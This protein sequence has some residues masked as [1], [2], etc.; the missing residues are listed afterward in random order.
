ME[1]LRRELRWLGFSGIKT[2]YICPVFVDTGFAKN[3]KSSSN[4]FCPILKP[5]D[6]VN[7][8]MHAFLT[9]QPSLDVPDLG[10]SGRF[11]E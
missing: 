2:T 4:F 8:A 9:D 7:K 10:F 5:E 1:G 11:I 3:P 6:V